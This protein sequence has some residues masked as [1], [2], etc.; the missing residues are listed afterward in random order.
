MMGC[1]MKYL[2][3]G[4]I[5]AALFVY[6]GIG[7]FCGASL[8]ALRDTEDMFSK[9][10]LD[11]E[12]VIY[13]LRISVYAITPVVV[14]IACIYIIL[15][16][17]AT[18][19]SKVQVYD[20][21]DVCCGGMGCVSLALYILYLL[22]FI[23][24]ALG[25]ACTIPMIFTV[26]VKMYTVSVTGADGIVPDGSCI[27]LQ[28]Y[29]FVGGVNTTLCGQTLKE[30]GDLAGSALVMYA[31]LLGGSALVLLGLIHFLMCGSANWGHVKDGLKR[32][33]YE[34]RRRQ[35]EAELHDM[36]SGS[37]YSRGPRAKVYDT[38]MSQMAYN[39]QLP[40]IGGFGEQQ[41]THRH[42]SQPTLSTER[43]VN[44]YY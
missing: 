43:L 31:I 44:D 26:M 7:L 32:R 15:G 2:P 40:P 24:L 34:S 12:T 6:C 10:G 30:F 37:S 20:D 13:A 35:E 25:G 23:W 11:A 21:E 3:Y 19:Q 28:Q 14:V 22:T 42:P 16:Y 8:T 33:D 17:A 4:S 1:S 38:S 18:K 5:V 41:Y 27:Y 36:G 29:G 9:T 39:P